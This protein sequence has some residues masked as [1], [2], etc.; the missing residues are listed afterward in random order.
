MLR[1]RH[2]QKL[3]DTYIRLIKTTD[4]KT[5]ITEKTEQERAISTTTE[6]V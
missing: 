2:R 3:I 4:N 1:Q 6:N 5:K